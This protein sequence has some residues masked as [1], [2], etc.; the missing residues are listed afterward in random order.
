MTAQV[1]DPKILGIERKTYHW[2]RFAKQQIDKNKNLLVVCSGPT[3]SGKSWSMLSYADLLCQELYNK[4]FRIKD[5]CFR[6]KELMDRVNS[7]DK[8]KVLI[9]DEAGI[10][11]SNRQWQSVTNKVINYLLQTF[12]HQNIILSFIIM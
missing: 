12:R 6:A 1:L 2:V 7:D 5:C 3:G 8:P 11:L 10:D 4:E 9:W